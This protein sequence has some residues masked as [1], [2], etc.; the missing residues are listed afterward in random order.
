MDDGKTPLEDVDEDVDED[1]EM[2]SDV[3]EEGE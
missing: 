1:A 2:S 3:D